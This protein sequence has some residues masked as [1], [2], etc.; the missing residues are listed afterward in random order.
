MVSTTLVE[1]HSPDPRLPFA[2]G[3]D[4]ERQAHL[5]LHSLLL[6]GTRHGEQNTHRAPL[7]WY[8]VASVEDLDGER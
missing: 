7:T 3:L 6:E 2:E 5:S 1:A 4:G 8:T